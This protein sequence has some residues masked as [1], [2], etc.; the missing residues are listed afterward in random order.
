MV[1]P[2]NNN[3]RISYLFPEIYPDKKDIN[4]Y[5]D[6]LKFKADAEINGIDCINK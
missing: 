3:H 2:T 4:I 1:A 6:M 5:T